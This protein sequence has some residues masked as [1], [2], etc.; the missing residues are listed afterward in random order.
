MVGKPNKPM[1]FPTNDQH[2]GWRLGV[3]PFKETPIYACTYIYIYVYICIDYHRCYY[4]NMLAIIDMTAIIVISTTN[5]FYYC[6]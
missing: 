3:P 4:S 2:L 1:G 5:Y 6:R